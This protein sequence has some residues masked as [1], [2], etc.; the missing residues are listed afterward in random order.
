MATRE[1]VNR[2][3]SNNQALVELARGD[4]ADFWAALDVL[5]PVEVRE[6]IEVFLPELVQTYGATAAVLA[7]DFYD[8][9]RDVPASASRFSA[10]VTEPVPVEQAAAT[11]RWGIDPLFQAE[12][13]PLKA[14]SAISGGVQRLV[15]QPGRDTIVES[16]YRDSVRTSFA[17]VPTGS[18]SCA[19]C[20]TMASRG[21]V[22]GSRASAGD[23]NKFHD[24]DDCAIVPVRS[25]EDYP[26]DYDPDALYEQY[27]S[28]HD[29]GMTGK[30]TFAAMREAYGIK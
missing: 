19:F 26:E 6:A 22:Y 20:L 21:A 17:R 24:N 9:L 7:A 15:L 4:F 28:V 3:R 14:F 2:Y 27:A 11:A 25:P 8:E 10:V 29:A 1:Q 5:Q 16:A 13:E 12:P 30:E 18:E 23:M